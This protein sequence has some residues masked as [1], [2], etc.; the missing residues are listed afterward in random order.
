MLSQLLSSRSGLLALVAPYM[1]LQLM[2]LPWVLVV[3]TAR[4]L[5]PARTRVLVWSEPAC[6]AIMVSFIVDRHCDELVGCR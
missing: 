2:V 5:S 3:L 6:A 1:L 4:M